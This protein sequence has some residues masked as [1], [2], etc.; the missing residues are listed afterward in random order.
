M[1]APQQAP[2]QPSVDPEQLKRATLASS[3]G[4]AL[5]YYDFYIYSL[6]S[7]LIFSHLFFGPLGEAGGLIASLGTITVGFAARPIG[8]LVFGHL[9]DRF[10]RKIVLI[11]TIALMGGSSFLIGLLPTYET[12]GV[13]APILLIVL[14]ILQGLGAGAEQ[15][16]ATVM[17]SEFAPAPRRGF[18]AALPFVGIQLGTLLGAGTFALLGLAHT[19]LLHSWLWR[20]PFL[21][22]AVLV[23]VAVYIRRRLKESPT[24]EVL[25]EQGVE[26]EK[27]SLG[28][29]IHSSRKNILIGIGLRMAE[30]GNSSIYTSLLIAFVGSLA[31]FKGQANPG[32]IGAVVAAALSMV[33]VVSFGALSDRFGR[34]RVYRFGALFSAIVAMPAFYLLTLGNP[35]L[36]ILVMAVGIGIGVQGML[37]PQCSMLPELFGNSHRYTG[38]AMAREI[39]AV[40]A[41]GLAPMLGAAFLAMTGNAWWTIGLYSLV[42]SLITFATTFVT[43]ETAGR[44]L[45]SLEDAV[46]GEV[47][48]HG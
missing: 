46:K 23:L 6:A 25:N 31:V 21:L 47:V 10:G 32:P 42:L 30:N 34:V 37:G 24:F 35:W 20:L 13:L 8:G 45:T 9:G 33:T 26:P 5:E 22:G 40:L 1:S 7:A 12:A 29:A 14:R 27:I 19:D 44:S 18:F 36:V 39:S 2:E 43:P 48:R 41:G 16:G 15:A 17:I 11:V 28:Q 3:V 38:V 4:S